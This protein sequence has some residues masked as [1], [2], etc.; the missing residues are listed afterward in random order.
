MQ[1]LANGARIRKRF[2]PFYEAFNAPL[3]RLVKF[4]ELPLCSGCQLNPIA[5]G[6]AQQKAVRAVTK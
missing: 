3:Y 1:S 4:A 2:D 6:M 5:L